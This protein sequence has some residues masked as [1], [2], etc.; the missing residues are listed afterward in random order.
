MCTFSVDSDRLTRG[1]AVKPPARHLLS[2]SK[3]LSCSEHQ[4]FSHQGLQ[5]Y[6]LT[7]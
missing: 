7:D 1:S 4:V 6:K 5:H 3:T 2:L